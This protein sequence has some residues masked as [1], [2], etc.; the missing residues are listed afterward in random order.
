MQDKSK[1]KEIQYCIYH[2]FYENDGRSLHGLYLQIWMMNFSKFQ[3]SFNG[4]IVC[5]F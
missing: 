4:V 5:T 2:N 3:I 1:I